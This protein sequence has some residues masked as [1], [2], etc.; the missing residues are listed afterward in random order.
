MRNHLSNDGPACDE[1]HDIDGV[2]QHVDV[3][4]PVRSIGL[5]REF[6]HIEVWLHPECEAVFVAR[7]EKEAQ[8]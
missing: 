2:I 8:K 4:W 5:G 7:L 1:C 6:G 3:A